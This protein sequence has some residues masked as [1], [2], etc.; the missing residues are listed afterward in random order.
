MG[1]TRKNDFKT[2]VMMTVLEPYDSR[3]KPWRVI[4][5]MTMKFRRRRQQIIF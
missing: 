1:E 2:R 4:V 3:F 5:N